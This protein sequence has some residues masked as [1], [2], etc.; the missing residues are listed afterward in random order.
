M[1]AGP[2]LLDTSAII[3]LPRLTD[4]AALPEVILI[5]TI[6]LAEMS[7]GPLVAT[8]E[9][10]RAARLQELQEAEASFDALPFDSDAA[11][12]FA[13]VAASLRSLGRKP[14]SRTF[15]AMIAAVAIANQ[16]PLFTCNPGDFDG[17]EGLTV[18]AVPHPD[19]VG[20]PL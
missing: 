16:L 12:A 14:S 10:E 17:I 7:V 18:V 13:G 9:T 2:G 11:R 19:S 6:T 5:S 4:E 15:D 20:S 1:V 8:D 3:L